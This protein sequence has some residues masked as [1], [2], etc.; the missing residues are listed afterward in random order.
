V[1]PPKQLKIGASVWTVA[2][3]KDLADTGGGD[4]YGRSSPKSVSI[5]M[6]AT[7][8]DQQMRDTLL[9]EVMHA[10]VSNI[11]LFKNAGVEERVLR[12]LTPWLLAVLRE[13]KNFTDYLVEK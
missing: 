3:V 9:H 5:E 2:V 7:Q 1:K 4:L 11:P 6:S 10:I 12:S 8:D 13:N